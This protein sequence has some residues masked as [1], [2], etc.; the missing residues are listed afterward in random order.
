MRASLQKCHN[1]LTFLPILTSEGRTNISTKECGN[2]VKAIST[3]DLHS[4]M[5]TIQISN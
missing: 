4:R 1:D 3:L 5:N 2:R